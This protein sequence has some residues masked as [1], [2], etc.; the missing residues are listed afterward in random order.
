M[1]TMLVV[2]DDRAWRSLYRMHFEGRFHVVEAVDGLDALA[3]LDQIGPDIIV[4]DLR[5]PR[6]DGVRFLD[7][8]ER[9]GHRPPVVFCSAAFPDA[10]S[11][12]IRGVQVVSKTPDLREL[13]NAV[14]ALMPPD[15]GEPYRA[16]AEAPPEDTPWRD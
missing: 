8:L 4:L 12:P 1:A 6:I 15:P 5:M 7:E 10:G 13:R 14:E 11:P 2:D 3:R 9:R 16:A